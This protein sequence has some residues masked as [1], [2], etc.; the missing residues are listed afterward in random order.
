[1]SGHCPFSDRPLRPRL[2]ASNLNQGFIAD[3]SGGESHSGGSPSRPTDLERD[4]REA[5]RNHSRCIGRL[6]WSS[7]VVR[8]QRH[9]HRAE[10]IIDQLWVHLRDAFN[11]GRVRPIISVFPDASE[12]GSLRIWNQQLC[13]YAGYR[14]ATGEVLGDPQ[15]IATTQRA[16]DWGWSPPRRRTAF[17]LLPLLFTDETGR[18]RWRQVPPELVPEVHITHPKVPEISELGLKWYPVPVVCDV[19]FQTATQHFPLAP[20][21]GW[22]MGTEI[23]ARNLGDPHRYNQLP[24]VAKAMGL[25]ATHEESLWRDRA[26][27]ELNFAVLHSFRA[28]GVKIV[29]HHTAAKEFGKFCDHEAQSNRSVSA[30]WTWIVPPISGSTTPVFHQSMRATDLC[31]RFI[32]DCAPS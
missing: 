8:D 18:N 28:A 5:W 26:I 16:L 3:S 20:F 11:G 19:A 17:D 30:D 31:P 15:N 23:G 7:L 13:G 6:Y 14:A 22:Y 32:R 24:A 25:D 21:N 4:A 9:C 10:Q 1:M 27:V 2:A 12:I 29:D